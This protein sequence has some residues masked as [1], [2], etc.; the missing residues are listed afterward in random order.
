MTEF[1]I[2]FPSTSTLEFQLE[3][4]ERPIAMKGIHHARI[5]GIVHSART[6]DLVTDAISTLLGDA[7]VHA[8]WPSKIAVKAEVWS[9]SCLQ[10]LWTMV[11]Q[12]SKNRV[13]KRD[14]LLQSIVHCLHTL[15]SI[16]ARVL[17]L[18]AP[19]GLCNRTALC[20]ISFLS[21]ILLMS[22]LGCSNVL[23]QQ[24]ARCAIQLA[25]SCQRS[26]LV[27]QKTR[28]TLGPLILLILN[29]TTGKSEVAANSKVSLRLI[30]GFA[31]GDSP[32]WEKLTKSLED[33]Q[34]DVFS[35]EELEGFVRLHDFQA[36]TATSLEAERPCKRVKLNDELSSVP[37]ES[38]QR[39]LMNRLCQLLGGWNPSELES[40]PDAAQGLFSDLDEREKIEVLEI[41]TTI[42]C[43]GNSKIHS[44]VGPFDSPSSMSRDRRRSTWSDVHRRCFYDILVKLLEDTYIQTS[45]KLK[46]LATVAVEQFASH[47]SSSEQ[48]DLNKSK[49]GKW[50]LQCLRSS[51]REVR[52]A[53]ANAL[54]A[55]LDASMDFDELLYRRNRVVAL[56]LLR[57]LST[58]SESRIQESSIIALRQIASVCGSEELNLVLLQLIDYLGHMNPLICG[59]A[60][61]ELRKLAQLSNFSVEELMRPYWRTIAVD[62]VKDLPSKPQKAQ[63]LADL[64]GL[65]VNQFLALTRAE[66]LP[67]LVMSRQADVIRRIASA[68][69]DKMDSWSLCNQPRTLP[70]ILSYMLTQ[71]TNDYEVAA[72]G[73]LSLLKPGFQPGDFIKLLK[74]NPIS[75]ATEILKRA[76]D[77]EDPNSEKVCTDLLSG[78]PK[79]TFKGR[80]RLQGVCRPYRTQGPLHKSLSDP[81]Q[82]DLL[83]L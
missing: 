82:D 47:S 22:W 12:Q 2:A 23:D 46:V 64:L 5:S 83:V 61:L 7:R 42:P 28:K 26:S 66:T 31:D 39:Q 8:S 43:V 6:I 76:A 57:N 27:T 30:S 10:Q 52:I 63:Q 55:F 17:T 14:D 58:S 36:V 11:L 67:F 13:I 56:N 1:D 4:S 60:H 21:D 80:E 75:V 44:E 20:N 18:H 35:A 65:T 78:D 50:C 24:F 41:L 69:G 3:E 79:L 9:Q 37:G 49:I 25:R 15:S 45:K 72:A 51:A 77:E 68:S 48:L 73:C 81:G 59:L 70:G 40:L 34:N 74:V 33:L 16:V 32:S 29:D 53:A 54:P 71:V 19:R 38:E 62:V